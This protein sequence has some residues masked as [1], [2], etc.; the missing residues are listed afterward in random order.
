MQF[1]GSGY[2]NS[3]VK[4]TLAHSSPLIGIACTNFNS[5]R[6]IP[7]IVNL[8]A[9][10]VLISRLKHVEDYLEAGQMKLV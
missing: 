7:T 10:D 9:G 5:T 4:F 6:G 3:F 8:S 2:T 1:A